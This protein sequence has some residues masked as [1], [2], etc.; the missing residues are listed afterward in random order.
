MTD[1]TATASGGETNLG[2]AGN[3]LG[4]SPTTIKQSKLSGS[5][6]LPS[7]VLLQEALPFER[8]AG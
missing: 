3:N 5:G 8:A 6:P 1:I 7:S 4:S 2:V